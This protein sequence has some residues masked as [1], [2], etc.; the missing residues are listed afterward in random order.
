M[1]E[2]RFPLI[3]IITSSAPKATTITVDGELTGEY[4]AA[5]AVCC[6]Q[7]IDRGK[8]VHL[9]LREVPNIDERGR[10]LLCRLAAQGVRLRAAGVYSSYIVA[11]SV[12]TIGLDG[13]SSAKQV[14][15]L[16][17]DDEGRHFRPAAET[18]SGHRDSNSVFNPSRCQGGGR[19]YGN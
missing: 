4:V 12:V 8:S 5:V 19:Q 10:A 9:T 2:R 11:G 7:A 13:R 3:R 16:M 14:N 6:K 17:S 18:K 15:S 1:I